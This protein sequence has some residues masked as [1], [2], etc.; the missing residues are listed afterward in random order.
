MGIL[1]HMWLMLK[2]RATEI[3]WTWLMVRIW[4]KASLYLSIIINFRMSVELITFIFPN[5]LAVFGL[6]A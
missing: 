5:P 6:G 1:T 2:M 3:F 4:V